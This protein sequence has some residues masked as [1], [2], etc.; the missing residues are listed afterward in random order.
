MELSDIGN[1][2]TSLFTK[3]D[4][5]L[6]CPRC[7]TRLHPLPVENGDMVGDREID[8]DPEFIH[9]SCWCGYVFSRQRVSDFSEKLRQCPDIFG[10]HALNYPDKDYH[11]AILHNKA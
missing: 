10:C 7:H 2:I 11:G 5:K 4:N 6:G 9:F 3:S 1:F 8:L